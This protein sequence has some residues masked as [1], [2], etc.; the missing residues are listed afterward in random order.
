MTPSVTMRVLH[1]PPA[2]VDLR[3]LR[4]KINCTVSGRPKIACSPA[5]G[6]PLWATQNQRK[7]AEPNSVKRNSVSQNEPHQ[8]AGRKALRAGAANFYSNPRSKGRLRRRRRSWCGIPATDP[9]AGSG[10]L[11]LPPI[12]PR[13]LVAGVVKLAPAGAPRVVP[14]GWRSA[15]SSPNFVRRPCGGA[16][17]SGGVSHSPDHPSIG[18]IARRSNFNR[19][20]QVFDRVRFHRADEAAGHIPAGRAIWRA[21]N[22]LG[23]P[24]PSIRATA[25]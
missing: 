23:L 15:P 20:R 11:P 6:P 4:A 8:N 9:R 17:A 1:R 10:Q 5:K 18:V 19:P 24:M 25:A 3:I 13:P 16:S 22:S 2:T 14:G 12:H 7:S 21:Q